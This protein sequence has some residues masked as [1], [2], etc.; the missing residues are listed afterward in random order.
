[1]SVE[2]WLIYAGAAILLSLTPGPNSLLSL[3]HGGLYGARRTTF[4]ALGS[5]CGFTLV[6]AMSMSGFSALLATSEQLFTV[7][8][9]VGAAYLVYLGIRTWRAPA[10]EIGAIDAA[11]TT[12]KSGRSLFT[13]GLV[14]A[15]SN[16]K[17]ILFFAA[18]LPQ[19]IDPTES[20]FNQFVVMAA[21]FMAVEFAFEI[22]LATCSQRLIPWLSQS[23]NT[24]WFQ[25]ITGTTFIGAG[26]L[27]A[28][29]EK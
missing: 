28:A 29:M 20:L 3:T 6:I 23:R 10:M 16:P 11:Q 14:V 17:A 22:F 13:A 25:R 24:R 9:W 5:I 1:M 8:K 21:T 18:F 12:G 4:T 19:F 27:L 26:T 2:L 15:I 7:I